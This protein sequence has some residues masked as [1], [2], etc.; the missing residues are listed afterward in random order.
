MLNEQESI[1][2]T[3]AAL[4]VGARQAEIIVVDGGSEDDSRSIARKRC[5][6][7]LETPRGRAIQLNAGAAKASGQILAFVHADTIVPR[8]FAADIEAA[9]RD[10]ATVGGRFHL[11]LDD[12]ALP[13]RLI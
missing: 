9:M 5:D 7:V 1:G 11:I 10:L 3:L 8:S 12:P 13:Y 2:A 6:I 4:R